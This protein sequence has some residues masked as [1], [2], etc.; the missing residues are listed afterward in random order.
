MSNIIYMRDL[1]GTGSM[2]PCLEGDPG[3][4]AYE[5]VNEDKKVAIEV[6]CC[7][8]NVDHFIRLSPEAVKEVKE[9]FR[10]LRQR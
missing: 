4:V 7:S 6:L 1:D 9:A 2:H 10:I 3:A 5:P 8:W